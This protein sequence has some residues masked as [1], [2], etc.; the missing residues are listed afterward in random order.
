MK[1]HRPPSNDHESRITR[2]EVIIENI[3]QTL[4]RMDKRFDSIDDSIRDLRKETNDNLIVL[5][6]ETNETT[7]LLK[8][9]IIDLRKESMSQFRWVIGTL[10]LS[11]VLPTILKVFHLI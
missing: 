4:I 2:L 8:R 1:T 11:V 6:K 10:I 7:N 3:N 5:R 9:E